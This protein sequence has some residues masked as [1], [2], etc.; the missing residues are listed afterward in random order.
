MYN[1]FFFF[2]SDLYTRI[3]FNCIIILTKVSI[4]HKISWILTCTFHYNL[5]MD[6]TQQFEINY[7]LSKNTKRFLFSIE[8][9]LSIVF[10]L[11]YRT[12]PSLFSTA[13]FSLSSFIIVETSGEGVVFRVTFSLRK[14]EK[15]EKRKRKRVVPVEK[16]DTILFPARYTIKITRGSFTWRNIA[17]EIKFLSFVLRQKVVSIEWNNRIIGYY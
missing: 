16:T 2:M 9:D 7:V 11:F 8:L 13:I 5:H 1:F 3:S 14:K 6:F 12:V 15:G 17:C 4:S 10:I